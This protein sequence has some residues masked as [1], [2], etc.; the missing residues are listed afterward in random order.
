VDP[1]DFTVDQDRLEEALAG[2]WEAVAALWPQILAQ[3]LDAVASPARAQE[4]AAQV[5]A[6]PWL[7]ETARTWDS[8][9]ASLRRAAWEE[10]GRRLTRA[11]YATRPFCV[12]CGRCCQSGSPSLLAEEAGLVQP[13]GVFYKK[14]Y[15]IRAGEPVVD[16]Q[17]GLW[18]QVSEERIKLL[19]RAGACLFYEADQ[20]CLVYDQRPAQCR[21][22]ACWQE[23]GQAQEFKGPFLSRSLALAHD[24]LKLDYALAHQASC[25][26][27]Q[28]VPLAEAAHKGDRQTRAKLEEMVAFDLHTRHFAKVKGHLDEDDMD[29]VLGRPLAVIL[30]PLD[31]GLEEIEEK[32]RF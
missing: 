18:R 23:T 16:R 9:E 22:Q 27:G 5:A 13:G 26:A 25:P 29:F 12:R 17:A 4:V 3:F 7:Q 15:T 6:D 31:L 21:A 19:E 28:I 20:G 2:P 24:R 1:L 11:A 10:L 30:S 8:A 14:A 32:A